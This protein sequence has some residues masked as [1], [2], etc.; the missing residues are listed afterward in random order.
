MQGIHISRRH[1]CLSLGSLILAPSVLA[2][3]SSAAD[4]MRTAHQVTRFSTARF[5]ATLINQSHKGTIQQRHLGGLSKIMADGE[6][7]ARLMRFAAPADLRGVATL[8]IERPVSDDDLWIYLPAFKRVRRLVSSNR[9]DPWVGSEFSLGDITG[10]KVADWQHRILSDSSTAILVESK[11]KSSKIVSD[12]G[13][14]RRLTSL[15]KS[16]LA[17]MRVE[18]F[19]QTNIASKILVSE[20]FRSF[21]G[22][23]G[24]VQPMRMMMQNV[25]TG[26]SSSLIFGSFLPGSHVREADL[27]PAA[28]PA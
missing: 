25:Q 5:E 19:D 27:T 11:P 1:I 20:D 18:F 24:K 6:A 2:Q 16:D 15:R 22:S 13:Y 14:A 17:T 9:A 3:A 28:M 4:L 26:N 10:H 12:T 7:S 21:E 8:T 23:R